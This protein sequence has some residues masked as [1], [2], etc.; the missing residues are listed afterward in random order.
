M[1][2]KKIMIN[3]VVFAI[4]FALLWQPII[5]NATEPT[6]HLIDGVIRGADMVARG[7]VV[8]AQKI[9]KV[10]VIDMCKATVLRGSGGTYTTPAQ[11]CTL[12]SAWCAILLASYVIHGGD[13]CGAIVVVPVLQE[14]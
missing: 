4:G 12:L 13:H 3:V 11:N 10:V 2:R 6:S 5:S 1:K 8:V 9:V 14:T 7:T